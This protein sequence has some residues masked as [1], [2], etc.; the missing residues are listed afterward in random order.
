MLA[1]TVLEYLGI[2]TTKSIG[3]IIRSDAA[4]RRRFAHK[5]ELKKFYE[6]Y[7]QR[8]FS[9]IL[10]APPTIN[11]KD[12]NSKKHPF[13]AFYDVTISSIEKVLEK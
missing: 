9:Q 12:T 6:P 4:T 13:T 5:R 3:N 2:S 8:I 1:K 11:E 10:E 7:S